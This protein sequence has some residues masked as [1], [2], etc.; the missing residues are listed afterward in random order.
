M[1]F[2]GYTLRIVDR[3]H[4]RVVYTFDNWV[5]TQSGEARSVGYPGSFVD[6]STAP[7]QAGK[8]LFTLAWPGQNGQ[9]RWLGRNIDVSVILLPASTK[10]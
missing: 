10:V 5:T 6:I 1:I 8:I 3:E 9:E 4:F 7:E 2:S